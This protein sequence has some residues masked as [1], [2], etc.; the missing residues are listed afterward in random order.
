MVQVSTIIVII[1]FIV[2]FI[3]HAIFYSDIT[4]HGIGSLSQNVFDTDEIVENN[5]IKT[6]TYGYFFAN[7]HE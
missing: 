4:K 3:F 1:L 2:S 7:T 5:D 6:T